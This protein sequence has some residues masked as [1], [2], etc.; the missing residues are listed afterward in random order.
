LH[1]SLNKVLFPCA[2]YKTLKIL[3]HHNSLYTKKHLIFGNLSTTTGPLTLETHSHLMSNRCNHDPT[4]CKHH[5]NQP[6]GESYKILTSSQ[7]LTIFA[8]SLTH[9]ELK[10]TLLS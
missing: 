6:N 3:A 2:H 9:H 4:T 5:P 1:S 8:K 10:T 7:L